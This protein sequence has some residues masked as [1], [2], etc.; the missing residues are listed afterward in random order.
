[1]S[2]KLARG[3]LEALLG[4]DRAA[5][6]SLVQIHK[7]RVRPKLAP[8]YGAFCGEEAYALKVDLNQ[9]G[10]DRQRREFH[11]L[12]KLDPLLGAHSGTGVVTPCH[13]S[14]DGRVLIT[15]YCPYPS[16][17][18]AALAARTPEDLSRIMA[19]AGKWVG[20][21]HRLEPSYRKAFWP[22]W[23]IDRTEAV[24]VQHPKPGAQMALAEHAIAVLS[25]EAVPLRGWNCDFG[26]IHGD[27][28]GV[29]LLCG[30]AEVMGLDMSGLRD[31]MQLLDLAQ[32][33]CDIDIRHPLGATNETSA[34]APAL[35]DGFAQG[36]GGRIDHAVL[37][38]LCRVELLWLWLRITPERLAASRT[39]RAR[40]D[41][42]E[43]RIR[44]MIAR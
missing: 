24:L 4:A 37:R 44:T 9:D 21:F 17:R 18:E 35:L 5:G 40:N 28:N 31:G 3:A 12:N 25:Q 26:L 29:N 19:R 38:F 42:L 22:G 27:L 8:V 30:E 15:R 10:P 6:F 16:L 7:K 33:L 1:M 14:A 2:R 36:Y 39:I 13:I 34:L 32:L 11:W 23:M 20:T 43:R 41:L